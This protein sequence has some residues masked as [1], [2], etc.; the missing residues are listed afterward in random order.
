MSKDRYLE[1]VKKERQQ[2]RLSKQNRC[3][4]SVGYAII[5]F[6]IT[7]EIIKKLKDRIISKLMKIKRNSLRTSD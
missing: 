2:K 4:I 7:I 6:T 1:L 3:V 5:E